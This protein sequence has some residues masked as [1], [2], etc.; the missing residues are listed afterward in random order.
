[1]RQREA[2]SFWIEKNVRGGRPRGGERARQEI[3]LWLGHFQVE[4]HMHNAM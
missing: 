2:A 3:L 4:K 1:M